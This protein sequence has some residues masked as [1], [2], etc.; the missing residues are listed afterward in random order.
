[1]ATRP[2]WFIWTNTADLGQA[3]LVAREAAGLTQT[4]LGRRAGVNRKLVYRLE[5]GKGNVRV[6][7]V[8][9]VLATL[10]LMPLIVP[11]ELLGALR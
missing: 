5:S 2:D 1:M 11:L 10:G 9:Q 4:E 3:I 8:M 7:S 6:D